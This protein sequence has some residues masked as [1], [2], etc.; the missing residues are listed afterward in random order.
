E[1]LYGIKKVD[2]IS[3]KAVSLS[4]KTW[5][6]GD[7]IRIRFLNGSVP[8]Q[9]AVKQVAATWLEY[10][11]LKFE[12]VSGEADVKI[13][14]DLDDHLITWSTIGTDCKL[15]PQNEPSVN[16]VDLEYYLE[17]EYETFQGNVLRAF[18]HIL[19]LGVENSSPAAEA[20]IEF[21]PQAKL[22]LMLFCGLSED[23][24]L[25]LLAFYG[26]SQTNYTD[27]DDSSIMVL[28]LPTT[29]VRQTIHAN[30]ELS[31]TDKEFIAALYPKIY[32]ER[33]NLTSNSLSATIMECAFARDLF[34]VNNVIYGLSPIGLYSFDKSKN[35]N[36]KAF[37]FTYS[38]SPYVV[39]NLLYYTGNAGPSGGGAVSRCLDTDNGTITNVAVRWNN[40]TGVIKGIDNVTYFGCAN[41]LYYLDTIDGA[42]KNKPL[43]DMNGVEI[44]N[45]PIGKLLKDSEGV[46]YVSGYKNSEQYIFTIDDD[47]TECKFY[48][49]TWDLQIMS[50]STSFSGKI[51]YR[52][53]LTNPGFGYIEN[54]NKIAISNHSGDYTPYINRDEKIYFIKMSI[55][56]PFVYKNGQL[57]S[58]GYDALSNANMIFLTMTPLK[59]SP[60]LILFARLPLE[61]VFNVYIID[62]EQNDT[63]AYKLPTGDLNLKNVVETSDGQI[64]FYGEKDNEVGLWKFNK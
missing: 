34:E 15:V 38:M 39:D 63:Y 57:N 60:E 48:L 36:V 41:G 13:G 30:T 46:V 61:P 32:F 59:H 9:E 44:V 29:V 10:A 1:R 23:E 3:T 49:P 51:Y 27:Y 14:F 21:R 7:T 26:T 18:G 40:Q 43:Y 47:T 64:Y 19:G 4:D 58:V 24:A 5:E 28:A 53:N 62:P 25:E 8:L 55:G 11:Y 33:V 42:I 45:L 6:S 56:V 37:D 31:D 16:F 35:P 17:E 2:K 22:Y 52:N 12:Y 50:L 54:G 20:V